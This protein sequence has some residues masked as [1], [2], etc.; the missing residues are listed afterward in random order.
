MSAEVKLGEYLSYERSARLPDVKQTLLQLFLSCEPQRCFVELPNLGPSIR[1]MGLL[2]FGATSHVYEASDGEQQ[3]M[4]NSA[5]LRNLLL[6][7]T[8]PLEFQST[9]QTKHLS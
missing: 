8:L 2:G 6:Y 7:L 1:V 5:M 9:A 4:S 3:V